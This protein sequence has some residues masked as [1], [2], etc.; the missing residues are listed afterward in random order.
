MLLKTCCSRPAS[1]STSNGSPASTISQVE[2]L[3]LEVW[4]LV[5]RAAADQRR[6]VERLQIELHPCRARSGSG[7]ADRRPCGSGAGRC[8]RWPRRP[9]AP[10]RRLSSFFST[11]AQPRIG[12]SGVRNSCDSTARNSSFA[13]A[14]ACSFVCR[15][16]V[17]PGAMSSPAAARRRGPGAAR[18]TASGAARAPAAAA[19]RCP[20]AG[21]TARRLAWPSAGPRRPERTGRAHSRPPRRRRSRRRAPATCR[22]P[23]GRALRRRTTAGRRSVCRRQRGRIRRTGRVRSRIRETTRS[24]GVEARCAAGPICPPAPNSSTLSPV[25][26]AYLSSAGFHSSESNRRRSR[27]A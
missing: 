10:A 7:R 23:S 9:G 5:S 22:R 8:A 19:A 3:L 6:Q 13:A 1:P 15:V 14:A 18:R 24:S 17:L 21:R 27:G 2:R 16:F 25:A 4:A 26:S 11:L 20:R 12:V